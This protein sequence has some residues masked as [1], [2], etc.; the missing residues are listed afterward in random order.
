M[1][2]IEVTEAQHHADDWRGKNKK[3]NASKQRNS[4]EPLP[5][6]ELHKTK[7]NQTQMQQA[8]KKI[9]CESEKKDPLLRIWET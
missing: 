7:K 3:N 9:C 5:P 4:V 1:P 6:K 8:T 2:I